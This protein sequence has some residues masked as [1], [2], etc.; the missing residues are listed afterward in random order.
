M[1]IYNNDID[2]NEKMWNDQNEA[3]EAISRIDK[4]KAL[5]SRVINLN[6]EIM[7]LQ[8]QKFKVLTDFLEYEEALTNDK[9]TASRITRLLKQIEV[10]K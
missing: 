6:T 5:L 2:P 7:D 9:D 1:A 8:E 10:W 3:D 4:H